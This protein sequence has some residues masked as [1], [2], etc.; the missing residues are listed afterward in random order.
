M[1]Q[2]KGRHRRVSL[3]FPRQE[4][5]CMILLRPGESSTPIEVGQTSVLVLIQNNQK[6]KVDFILSR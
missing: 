1:A 5:I 3:E 4:K 2:K 6:D